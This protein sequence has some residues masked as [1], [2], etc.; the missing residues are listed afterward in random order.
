M[1]L[2]L[3]LACAGGDPQPAQ[4]PPSRVAAVTAPA[5]QETPAETPLEWCDR[6]PAT[7]GAA[8]FE[9]P[10]L[11]GAEPPARGEG[12]TWI[13]AWATWCKP[14]IE[15]MPRL[16]EWEGKL[17]DEVEAGEVHFLSLDATAE[18]VSKFQKAHPDLPTGVR[19]ADASLMNDWVTSLGLEASAAALPIHIFLDAEGRTRCVYMGGVEASDYATVKAVLTGG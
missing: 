9:W 16:A 17:Q 2:L 7:E 15:E 5:P 4:A 8:A 6:F 14:C 11:D 1:P 19:I 18:V 13:N 10:K 3:L 12:W